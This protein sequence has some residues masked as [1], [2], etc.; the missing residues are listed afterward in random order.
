MPLQLEPLAPLNDL[1]A[2]DRAVPVLNGAPLV[3]A[4]DLIDEDPG[5]ARTEFDD[6]SLAELAAAIAERGVKQ[7]I[8]ARLHPDQPGRWMLNFGARRLRASKLAGKTEIPAFVD[9]AADSCDQVIENEQCEAL[10][11]MDLALFVQRMRCHH[12]HCR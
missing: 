9:E 4:I 12:G 2:L 10:R 3:I 6:K 11:P 1:A 5:Q 7:P 8:S